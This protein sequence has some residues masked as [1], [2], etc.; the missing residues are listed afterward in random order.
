MSEDEFTKDPQDDPIREDKIFNNSYYNGDKLKDSEEY[1]FSKK[2]DVFT[3]KDVKGN[4]CRI[5]SWFDGT[6]YNAT[7]TGT[8]NTI[9]YKHHKVIDSAYFSYMMRKVKGTKNYTR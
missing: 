8:E 4:D 6:K 3:F 2:G 1:E 7:I 5:D 9:T